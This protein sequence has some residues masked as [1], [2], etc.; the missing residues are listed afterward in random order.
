LTRETEETERLRS[1]LANAE[2]C[3]H[4]SEIRI[5]TL[6]QEWEDYEYNDDDAGYW[7]NAYD[8]ESAMISDLREEVHESSV[9]LTDSNN[10]CAQAHID[11]NTYKGELDDA[12]R[13]I[14][15]LS[16]VVSS[17]GE[18][19]QSSIAKLDTVQAENIKLKF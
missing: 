3:L 18:F 1:K 10:F 14:A 9:R 12:R 6:T 13:E 15:S 5:G 17:N 4:D 7:R 16:A 11:I 19:L 2:S 8:S